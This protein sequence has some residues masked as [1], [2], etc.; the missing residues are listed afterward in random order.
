MIV[1]D[2]PEIRE[3]LNFSLTRAGFR[4]TEEESSESAP[5]KFLNQLPDLVIVDWML[6][7]MSG[8]DLAKRIKGD[9]LTNALPLLML[10]AHSEEP[11]VLKSFGS[12]IDD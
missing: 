2:E 8:A 3:L 12:G 10:T 5:Q 7:E 9:V 11:D 4:C 6:E 1:K